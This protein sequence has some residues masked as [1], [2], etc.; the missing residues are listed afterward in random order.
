LEFRVKY[1][2]WTIFL[3]VFLKSVDGLAAS[4]ET[5]SNLAAQAEKTKSRIPGYSSGRK[6]VGK[7]R[8]LFYRAPNE[9]CP[10]KGV[11]VIPNDEVQAYS[12][13]ERFTEV[14]YWDAKGNDVSGWVLTSRLVETGTGIGPRYEKSSR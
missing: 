5:C 10:M 14:V 11:F 6:V 12:D 4:S 7:G 8:A 13:V 3:V 2:M 1:L 9:S